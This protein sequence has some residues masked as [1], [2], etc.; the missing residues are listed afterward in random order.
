MLIPRYLTFP[1]LN[2]AAELTWKSWP[3][4][5]TD[6][7]FQLIVYSEIYEN[8]SISFIASERETCAF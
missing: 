6:D 5:R 3:Y 2:G 1:T 8:L 7:L 4:E